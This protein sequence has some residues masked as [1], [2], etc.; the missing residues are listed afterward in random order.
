RARAWRRLDTVVWCEIPFAQQQGLEV[1]L[2]RVSR[3]RRRGGSNREILVLQDRD[4]RR[5]GNG[6]GWHPVRN[7]QRAVQSGLGW[8]RNFALVQANRDRRTASD[9]RNRAL[10]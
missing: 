9:G 3:G 10:G 7:A 1:V 4:Q 5:F 8:L 2:A 6:N